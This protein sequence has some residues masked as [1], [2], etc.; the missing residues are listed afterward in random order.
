MPSDKIIHFAVGALIG[1]GVT[2]LPGSNPVL[3]FCV[4]LGAGCAKEWIWDAWMQKGTFEGW[5]AAATALGGAL[6]A[7]GFAALRAF[8]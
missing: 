1:L 7:G 3:G 8:T 5:D 4:A 6:S 2:V